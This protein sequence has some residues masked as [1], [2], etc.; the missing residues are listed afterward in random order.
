MKIFKSWLSCSG[1]LYLS[2]LPTTASVPL[3]EDGLLLETVHSYSP[4]I[5]PVTISVWL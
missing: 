1:A 4:T 2:F 5:L 3:D